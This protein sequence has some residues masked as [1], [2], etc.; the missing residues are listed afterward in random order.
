MTHSPAMPTPG[1]GTPTRG[2]LHP[3]M[4]P[5][6]R[7]RCPRLRLGSK[8]GGTD[9]WTPRGRLPTIFPQSKKMLNP[10]LDAN[11]CTVL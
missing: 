5:L 11:R 3:L 10:G 1:C 7:L 4:T 9:S 2:V 6:C 8:R